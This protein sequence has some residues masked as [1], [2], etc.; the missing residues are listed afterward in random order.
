MGGKL[1]SAAA[2]LSYC[3]ALN[4][5]QLQ[6]GGHKVALHLTVGSV[7]GVAAGRP[8]QVADGEGAQEVVGGPG[9][10]DDVVGIEPEDENQRAV[11]DPLQHRTYCPDGDETP[12]EQLAEGRLE[13]VDGHAGEDQTDEV[14]NEKGA[15]AV[16]VAEI[17]EAP[18]VAQADGEANAGHHVVQLVGPLSSRGGFSFEVISFGSI[19][20][21]WCGTCCCCTS[22]DRRFGV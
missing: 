22:G 19:G 7:P 4:L 11:A 21:A 20:C 2:I 3:V 12:A 13:Q 9:D 15:A 6:T 8:G 16:L 10:D 14:G 1:Y 5:Q 17:G 18:D